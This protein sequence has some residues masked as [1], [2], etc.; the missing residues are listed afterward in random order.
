ME[1]REARAN[2]FV[3]H[4]V[5]DTDS[6]RHSPPS[7]KEPLSPTTPEEEEELEYLLAM[8]PEDSHLREHLLESLGHPLSQEQQ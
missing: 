2:R 8:L 7:S 4:L 1:E 6:D 5:G 3:S